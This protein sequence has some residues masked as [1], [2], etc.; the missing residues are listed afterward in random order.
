MRRL[1]LTTLLIA[2]NLGLLI[3]A[4]AGVA[5]LAHG[6]L[7]ARAAVDQQQAQ[8]AFIRSLILWGL[9]VG[10]VAPND[11]ALLPCHQDPA[12]TR[13]GPQNRR[14]AKVEIGSEILGAILG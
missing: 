11:P 8:T 3:I 2:L 7:L 14:G 5:W 10:V 9:A 13:E 4:A 6:D 1:H 12:S